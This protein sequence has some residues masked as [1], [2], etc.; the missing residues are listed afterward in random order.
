VEYADGKRGA[1]GKFGYGGTAG[2]SLLLDVL[3]PRLARDFEVDVGVKHSYLFAEFTYADV[4]DFWQPG[5]D[6][7]SQHWM[8]GLA[9]DF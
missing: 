6:L 1:G 5:L 4:N 2:L 7:S 9:F 8:F 3:E